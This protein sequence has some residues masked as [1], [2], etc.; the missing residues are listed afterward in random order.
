MLILTARLLGLLRLIDCLDGA[1]SQLVR[2][3]PARCGE[4]V[5]YA[6]LSNFQSLQCRSCLDGQVRRVLI[7]SPRPQASGGVRSVDAFAPCRHHRS[8]GRCAIHAP[9]PISV[10]VSRLIEALDY[11]LLRCLVTFQLLFLE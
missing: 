11:P 2:Q 9:H 1:N 8:L 4:P 5:L 10:L 3:H 6:H 7:Q